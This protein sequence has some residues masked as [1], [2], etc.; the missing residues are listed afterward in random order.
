M[1]GDNGDDDDDD[2]DADDADEVAILSRH[3]KAINATFSRV[4]PNKLED[5]VTKRSTRRKVISHG[6]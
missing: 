1:V 2:S 5:D 6:K 3:R 4:P